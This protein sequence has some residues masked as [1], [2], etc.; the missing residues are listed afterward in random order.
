MRSSLCVLLDIN[1]TDVNRSNTKLG[2]KVSKTTIAI[3][4]KRSS[5]DKFDERVAKLVVMRLELS[6]CIKWCN[7]LTY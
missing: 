3:L 6:V 2:M 5:M 7:K 4:V 1:M